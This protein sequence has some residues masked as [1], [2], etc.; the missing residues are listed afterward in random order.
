MMNE[1]MSPEGLAARLIRRVRAEAL[2]RQTGYAYFAGT[3]V[4]LAALDLAGLQV[5]C[6]DDLLALHDE[7]FVCMAYKV[8]LGRDPDPEGYASYATLLRDDVARAKLRILDELVGSEEA[9]LRGA[10][11]PGLAELRVAMIA[12]GDHA[13]AGAVTGTG[14]V[15]GDIAEGPVLGGAGAQPGLHLK[16]DG[17]YRAG[18]LLSLDGESFV[19]AAYLAILRRVPDP[20]GFRHFVAQLNS[21]GGKIDIL[22]AMRDSIEGATIGADIEGLSAVD[23]ADTGVQGRA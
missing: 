12:T 11:L 6:A 15:D 22:R 7:I 23:G 21:G 5:S 2:R 19:W 14:A 3:V 4:P 8:I 13:A 20:P 18:D 9:R 10:E 1:S 17:R 16:V